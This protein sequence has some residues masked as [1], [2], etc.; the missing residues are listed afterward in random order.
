[1]AGYGW[2]KPLARKARGPR[3]V[4]LPFFVCQLALCGD[5]GT[6]GALRYLESFMARGRAKTNTSCL[7]SAVGPAGEQLGGALLSWL[8][9]GRHHLGHVLF[10]RKLFHLHGRSWLGGQ[11]P[12]SSHEHP[13][14]PA[15]SLSLW[16]YVWLWPSW[17]SLV[18]H[19]AFYAGS[20]VASKGEEV[21][22]TNIFQT[23]SLQKRFRCCVCG[24]D[25]W[26]KH[27]VSGLKATH[28]LR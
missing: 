18:G 22:I 19:G 7:G 17:W 12:L 24:R 27:E 26:N 8:W 4:L 21:K 10:A 9:R 15:K 11:R 3:E 14:T 1:M 23:T 5:P 6:A 13:S 25:H 28:P 2:R 20:V 16:G